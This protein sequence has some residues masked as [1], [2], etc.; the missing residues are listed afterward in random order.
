MSGVKLPEGWDW[1][2]RCTN[3]GRDYPGQGLP[4][5]CPTCGGHYDLVGGLRYAPGSER[6]LARYSKSFPLPPDSKFYSLGEGNTPLVI[7]ETDKG[8]VYMKCEHLNPTGSFKDR[9]TAVLISALK[10]AGVEEAVEDSSGNAGASFAA[11]AARAGIRARIFIPD[12][13]SGP[14]RA[15]IEAYGA[16]LVPIV[17]PRS[18][19][20]EAVLRA[21]D[22]GSVYAS[23]AHLPHLA[24]GMATIAFELVEALG[25][26]PGA[27]VLPVGQGTLFLGAYLGFMSLIEAGVTESMPALIGVQAEA[28]APLW[29]VYEGGSARLDWVRERETMAEGIRILHPLRGDAVLRAVEETEGAIVVVEEAEIERGLA[30]LARRGF[31]VEPTSA[32]I[33]PA[34]EHLLPELPEPVVA[35][36]TGSGFK[37]GPESWPVGVGHAA[38]EHAAN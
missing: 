14:K 5:R 24:A 3:C 9:G 36:L 1:P 11:Y 22:S 25:R 20:T 19:A 4:Y 26:A 35:V 27:L 15:Q 17:G 16:E 6:G 12:Y 18:A 8:R 13:A 10:V 37:S 28:C 34:L 7:E 2:F 38:S 29:A 32:V 31:L 23:H 21:V 33:W 30:E